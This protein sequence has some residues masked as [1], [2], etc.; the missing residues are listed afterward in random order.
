MH[1]KARWALI[2]GVVLI[3]LYPST[4]KLNEAPGSIAAFYRMFIAA[5]A[6]VPFAL[7]TGKIQIPNAKALIF[8]SLSGL[9]IAC[10]VGLWNIS[11]TESTVTQATL[12]VNLSPIWV[13]LLSYIL[14]KNKPNQNFWIG[15][16]V[17]FAGMFIILD[18]QNFADFSFNRAFFYAL[19]AGLFY[20]GY[21]LSN[22]KALTELNLI[23]FFSISLLSSSLFLGLFNLGVGQSFTGFSS[24][25]WSIMLVQGLLIQLLAWFLINY[26]IQHMRATQVSLS[27]LGQAFLS[28]IFAVFI[29]HENLSLRVVLGGILLIAGIG[30][31]FY[32]KK[33]LPFLGK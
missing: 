4:V 8:A 22:K 3:S 10:D 5:L 9:F 6:L 18:L 17:A 24:F 13:G 31:T 14:F 7:L 11:I 30:L 33:I 1:N 32:P 25:S 16:A 28:S 2:V 12:L 15:A 20:A 27:L 26:A 19:L 21:I 29:L 23:S